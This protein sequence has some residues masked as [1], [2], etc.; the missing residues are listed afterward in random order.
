LKICP[1]RLSMLCVCSDFRASTCQSC[2]TYADKFRF[3][4]RPCRAW[5]C[6][7]YP[8]PDAPVGFEWQC[9]TWSLCSVAVRGRC[10]WWSCK[11]LACIGSSVYEKRRAARIMTALCA[12]WSASISACGPPARRCQPR[13]RFRRLFTSTA[14]TIGFARRTVAAPGEAQGFLHPTQ[15][16][17]VHRLPL[18][19]RSHKL[20]DLMFHAAQQKVFIK[21]A[22]RPVTCTLRSG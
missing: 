2:P 13:P 4:G 12:S 15:F 14:P 21:K 7:T 5:L 3:P 20:E 16:A 1:L 22:G 6:C 9:V 19:F 10:V 17:I 18:S 8:P 11:Q